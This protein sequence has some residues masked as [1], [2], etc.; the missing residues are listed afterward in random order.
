MS[1]VWRFVFYL[2]WSSSIF[3]FRQNIKKAV[4]KSWLLTCTSNIT[5]NLPSYT[6]SALKR[7]LNFCNSYLSL[8]FFFYLEYILKTTDS[9]LRNGPT[10]QAMCVHLVGP[11]SSWS[12]S[13]WSLGLGDSTNS[14]FDWNSWYSIFIWTLASLFGLRNF[15]LEEVFSKLTSSIRLF[16]SSFT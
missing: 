3:Q 9:R 4:S 8:L 1:K 10:V 2:G 7:E 14:E 11:Q 15:V 13:F 12:I 16:S 6:G 5:L